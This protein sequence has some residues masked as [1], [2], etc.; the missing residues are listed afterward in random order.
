MSAI[1]YHNTVQNL[2]PQKDSIPAFPQKDS[3]IENSTAKKSTRNFYW[4]FRPIA[5]FFRLTGNLPLKNLHSKHSQDVQFGY[6][7]IPVLYVFFLLGAS[8]AAL[9]YFYDWGAFVPLLH[10]RDYAIMLIYLFL[11]IFRSLMC[12]GFTL[13]TSRDFAKLIRLLDEF[14]ERRLDCF[15]DI[16]AGERNLYKWTVVPMIFSIFC[17]SIMNAELIIFYIVIMHPQ[18]PLYYY[19]LIAAFSILST[20]Q[21]A[22]SLLYTYF[23][24]SIKSNFESINTTFT[25]MFALH[26][27]YLDKDMDDITINITT[28]IRNIR[29]LHGM[30]SDANLFPQKD[31]IIENST[32]KKSTRNFYWYFRP[33]AIFF[34]LTGN[35]P[36]KNLHS[37]HSQDV[38]FGYCTIPVLYV[39][40]L[41]GASLAALAY[42]YDWGAFVPLLHER[43]YAIMLIYLFL[44]IFRSLMCWGFTLT[45]SR[46]FAKL[47]RLLD[48]FDER[49]IKSNFESINTTF[50]Q[51]FALHEWYLDKD[52]DDITINMTTKIRN[53]RALHGM[54]SDAV[55]LLNKCYERNEVTAETEDAKIEQIENRQLRNRENIQPPAR[56][57]DDIVACAAVVEEPQTYEEAKSSNEMQAEYIAASD[58]VAEIVW[59][60]NFLKE[61]KISKVV[62]SAPPAPDED[63]IIQNITRKRS[64]A[65]KSFYWYF[66]PV[67]IFLRLLGNLPLKN[68][69]SGN[70]H[71]V[72]FSYCSI[73]VLYVLILFSGS[74]TAIA[75]FHDWIIFVTL[76]L[77]RDH[78]LLLVYMLLIIFRSLFCCIF[79][80]KT[81][82]NFAKLIKLLDEFD[83]RRMDYFPNVRVP[84]RTLLQWTISPMLYGTFTMSI[85][86]GEL[87]FFYLAVMQPKTSL[88]YYTLIVAFCV[89]STWQVAPSFLYT[90][91]CYSIRS[92]FKII[93]KTFKEVFSLDEWYLDKEIDDITID[94]TIKMRKIRALH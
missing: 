6:C 75:H 7:T 89:F 3:I 18:V 48:E 52:L 35:L 5:I 58:A 85:M 56:Y 66:R 31:S 44:I 29:A 84:N 34:R 22:P 40:F 4:Y 26:E 65:T 77:V 90:Y 94:M 17:M 64:T 23:S 55:N 81:S 91:F 71:D 61:I 41:L 14:D 2:F 9:A 53:I 27:W 46:D 59:L 28:K 69:H 42:F 10:E 11:I 74:L 57:R 25:Q 87:T 8:L 86:V 76:V 33:I 54:M 88:E 36:L 1:S 39:F 49:S 32:A 92:N 83:E 19:S 16:C 62:A 78:I 30:M 38:Q 93:N 15:P 80:L 70:C 63:A 72:Q 73:P 20:W 12:W 50:T 45:T 24:Y 67:A 47:I 82:K 21:I 79:S 60:R 68:L 51:M 13:T 43:D 37:K